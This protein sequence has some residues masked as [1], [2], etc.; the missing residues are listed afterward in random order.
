MFDRRVILGIGIGMIISSLLMMGFPVHKVSE[1][2]IIKMAR[3]R[4][5]VF[6]DEVKALYDKK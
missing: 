5:M 2:E 1:T 3:E 6:P 4:G